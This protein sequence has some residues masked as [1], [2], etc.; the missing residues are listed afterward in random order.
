[1]IEVVH[2]DKTYYMSCNT[3]PN[4]KETLCLGTTFA[5]SL[6][7]EEDDEVFVSFLKD[8]PVLTKIYVAPLTA[9]DRE[10]LVGPE[11]SFSIKITCFLSYLSIQPSAIKFQCL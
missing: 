7:I 1:M 9:N 2:K 3:R 4:L 5:R 8:V 10:I 11:K 6:K